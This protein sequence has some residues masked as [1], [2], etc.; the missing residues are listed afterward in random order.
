MYANEGAPVRIALEMRL[1]GGSDI[2]LAPQHGND[3]FG[4]VS[5][6][7]LTTLTTPPKLWKSFRQTMADRWTSY[8]DENGNFLNAR[9]HWAKEWDG[10]TVHGKPIKQYLREDAYSGV[11][12]QFQKTFAKIV[13]DRGSSVEDTRARFGNKLMEELLF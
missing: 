5:I 9:P 6:E 3:D 11:L 8:K 1:T 13:T 7:V 2:L 4:T 12:P 10:L